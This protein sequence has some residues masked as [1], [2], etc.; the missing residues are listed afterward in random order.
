MPGKQFN[1]Y[2]LG[3]DSACRSPTNRLGRAYSRGVGVAIYDGSGNPLVRDCN[4]ELIE[5]CKRD[6]NGYYF[7]WGTINGLTGDECHGVEISPRP[8]IFESDVCQ[9]IMSI[10]TRDVAG[11]REGFMCHLNHCAFLSENRNPDYKRMYTKKASRNPASDRKPFSATFLPPLPCPS[12]SDS[13]DKKRGR[14]KP[15]P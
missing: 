14:G 10:H 11:I 7:D 3:Q 9:L 4:S 13:R 5:D 6:F 15:R 2:P 8:L 12:A 1:I